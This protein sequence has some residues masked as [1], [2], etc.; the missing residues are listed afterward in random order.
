M[1]NKE[2][3]IYRYILVF[4]LST[5]II[6]T[7]IFKK[8]EISKDE[9]TLKELEKNKIEMF[10]KILYF[11]LIISKELPENNK[12]L[13]YE[14]ILQ[15]AIFLSQRYPENA[16][17]FI[18]N[19]ILYQ[20]LTNFHNY[21]FKYKI[22]EM[23]SLNEEEK[24]YFD[25]INQIYQRKINKKEL[26]IINNNILQI[27]MHKIVVLD[28][29]T[30]VEK[31]KAQSYLNQLIEE[32]LPFQFAIS[33]FI[34]FMIFSIFFG[35]F[36]VIRFFIK[37]PLPF[38]GTFI[39]SFDP[40]KVWVLLE[41]ALIYLFLYIPVN[42][43]LQN[44]IGKYITN[45]LIFQT[46]YT[47]FI[48]IFSFYYL[49]T[50][51]GKKNVWNTLWAKVY[52]QKEL[53]NLFIKYLSLKEEKLHLENENPSELEIHKINNEDITKSLEKEIKEKNLKPMNP[54]K[55]IING[56]L[57]FVVIFPIS[58][59]ILILSVLTT[60]NDI[61]IE[62]AHPITFYIPEYFWEVFFL[63]VII[64][65]ITE[66]IVFRNWIYGFFR[67]YL[68]IFFSSFLSGVFFAMLHPQGFIAYPY[69]IFLGMSLAI[70]REFR[71]GII[72]PM[73]THACVNGLAIVMSYLFYKFNV[74]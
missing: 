21:K 13:I 46:L 2:N 28:Y 4:L 5:S 73:I 42:Y 69:L 65:P 40:Q 38:Y 36:L 15:N 19:Y 53:K 72:S 31:S 8:K 16:K 18:Q 3:Q 64:A 63:T 58:F 20:H 7:L 39:R 48:F 50:E 74:F 61:Q 17:V 59:V 9:F 62:N 24:K 1:Q 30:I 22:P 57:A 35:F 27:P 43:I 44:L 32:I 6:F 60:G 34:V 41:T 10:Y 51:F 37:T 23:I 45:V 67:K 52:D 56:F 70:L 14:Q 68:S 71:P 25:L 26:E 12:N 29:Y 49:N 33:I 47:I 55:E 11:Q 54:F 66:E